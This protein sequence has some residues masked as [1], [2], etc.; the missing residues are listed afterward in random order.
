MCVCACGIG[1]ALHCA[2]VCI[3]F[4]RK[5][6][7]VMTSSHAYV[8]LKYEDAQDAMV[9]LHCHALLTGACQYV[10][11]AGDDQASAQPGPSF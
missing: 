5:A 10:P 8:N 4:S 7:L 3:C 1:V 11:G 9:V 6:A 2:D